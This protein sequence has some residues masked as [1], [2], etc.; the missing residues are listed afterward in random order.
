VPVTA[1]AR[2]AG[3]VLAVRRVRP[4]R[5]RRLARYRLTPNPRGLLTAS[6]LAARRLTARLLAARRLTARPRAASPRAPLLLTAS[7]LTA[8]LLTAS[9]LTASP[10]SARLLAAR[11]L[12]ARDLLPGA[13]RDEQAARLPGGRLGLALL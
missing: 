5:P 12:A 1:A 11:L 9:L 3:P 13:V 2:S 6:P 7:L 8:S 10:V 4:G